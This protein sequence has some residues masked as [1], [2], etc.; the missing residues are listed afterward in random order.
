M[1]EKKTN[2]KERIVLDLENSLKTLFQERLT[3]LDQR[4]K[5]TAVLR[6]AIFNMLYMENEELN[7]FIEGGLVN[8]AA[9][10]SYIKMALEAKENGL[11]SEQY[12]VAGPKTKKVQTILSQYTDDKTTEKEVK[13]ELERIE[14]Q[15]WKESPER[16]QEMLNNY[17]NKE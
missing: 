17:L 9:W 14:E 11:L 5:M 6:C 8:G 15:I 1:A 16:K 3:N 13:V 2:E 4:L 7:R 12:S 10:D